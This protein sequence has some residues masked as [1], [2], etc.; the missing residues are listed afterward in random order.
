MPTAPAVVRY[1]GMV[2]HINDVSALPSVVDMVASRTSGVARSDTT[3]VAL[4]AYEGALAAARQ[5]GCGSTVAQIT[6][7]LKTAGFL[8][9]AR[10]L[11]AASRS[12]GAAAHPDL[13]LVA[14]I[15]ALRGHV[16]R[17]GS[18]D[19]QDPTSIAGPCG[20]GL[21]EPG[22]QCDMEPP[23]PAFCPADLQDDRV[24]R[25]QRPRHEPQ[26]DHRAAQ[27]AADFVALQQEIDSLRVDIFEQC[28]S[29]RREADLRP[30][31]L[32]EMHRS[33]ND[34]L[35]LLTAG[36]SKLAEFRREVA[37]LRED[38]SSIRM[39]ST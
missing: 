38:V 12:R 14:E 21:G 5:R 2:V 16:E 7:Q 27:S 34:R 17:S 28:A 13:G 25:R 3:S 8:S 10:R 11:R 18:D 39:D 37:S 32:D 1:G 20:D 35:T 6:S 30:R 26:V 22:S 36:P 29:I 9:L 33:Y 19:S 4:E 31:R 15:V 24:L 23:R